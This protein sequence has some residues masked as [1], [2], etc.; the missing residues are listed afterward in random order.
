MSL[1]Y[2]SICFLLNSSGSTMGRT[3]TQPTDWI[4]SP[5]PQHHLANTTCSG[6]YN[7]VVS[8]HVH[9]IFYQMFRSYDSFFSI[10]H[11]WSYHGKGETQPRDW[12]WPPALHHCLDKINRQWQ[13]YFC[14]EI[15][16]PLHVWWIF[17]SYV[18]YFWFIDLNCCSPNMELVKTQPTD[19]V[20]PPSLHHCLANIN[21]QQHVYFEG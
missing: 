1:K 11:L 16:S 12:I 17:H 7:L 15:L 10:H 20:W 3:K 8:F 21:V 6:K 19:W 14:G 13:V 18:A 9:C 2:I 4:I 5:V